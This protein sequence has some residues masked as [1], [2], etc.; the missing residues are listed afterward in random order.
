MSQHN[1][2]RG[3]LSVLVNFNAAARKIIDRAGRMGLNI[4]NFGRV[5]KNLPEVRKKREEERRAEFY[6]TNRLRA[7]LYGKVF[8][9]QLL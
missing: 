5:Y 6:K 8:R 7:Q 1:L 9:D 2:T 4:C 3:L